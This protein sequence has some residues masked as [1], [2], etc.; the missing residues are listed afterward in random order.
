MRRWRT[1]AGF[2]FSAI[3]VYLAFRRIDLKLLIA[4]LQHANYLYILPI[5]AII[6]VSMALRSIRWGYLLR[7]I[8]KVSFT[9]LFESMMISFM[10][11]NV[12]PARMGDIMRAYIIGSNE[13]ITKGAAFATVVV[14]R[15]FDGLTILGIL[16]VFVAFVHLPSEEISFKKGLLVGAY[17]TMVI[18]GV[19]L[20]IVVI[21]KAKTNWSHALVLFITRPLSRRVA[22]RGVASI[23]SFKEGLR[24]LEDKEIMAICLFYSLVIWGLFAY[25]IYLIGLAFGVELSVPALLLVLL[26]ICLVMM[27]PSTPGHIGPYHAAVAYA[28]NLYHIP[29]EKALSLSIV[30]HAVNYI[31]VTLAGLLYLGKH[32]LSIKNISD[33]G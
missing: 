20:A 15:L 27:I 21:I 19:A 18:C 17:I 33:E 6:F 9:S 24:S 11:N 30:F 16:A 25:S 23:I 32:Q 28:L 22:K 7:P 5:V 4:H 10:A 3:I 31:P 29:L 1:C 13:Q 2:A 26:A 12:L 8:K 14:E